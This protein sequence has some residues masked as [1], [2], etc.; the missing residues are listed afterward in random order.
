MKLLRPK[1]NEKIIIQAQEKARAFFRTKR[2]NC[3]ES[4]FRAI[5]ES[6]ET[7]LPPQVSSLMTPLGGGVGIAGENCGALLAGVMALALVYGRAD[8][9]EALEE[10]RRRLW[11]VYALYNQLP[12]RFK[13]KYGSLRCWDLTQPYIYGS[14]KCRQFCEELI[15]ETAG[16][17]AELL[18]EAKEK[19]LDFRFQENL[20]RQTAE[21]TG[22][23]V[24]ELIRLKEKG[25]PFPEPKIKK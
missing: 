10:H 13:E 3:A 14:Q 9:G 11:K 18:L 7:D 1:K 24:E 15:A 12:H 21:A 8:R 6:V 23:S 22:L 17:V 19:D 25:E 20:L 5:Y 2:A 16:M 4:V